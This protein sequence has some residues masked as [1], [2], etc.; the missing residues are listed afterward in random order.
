M[1]SRSLFYAAILIY[2]NSLAEYSSVIYS[3]LGNHCPYY[4]VLM[5]KAGV[6]WS[7]CWFSSINLIIFSVITKKSSSKKTE[8]NNICLWWCFFCVISVSTSIIFDVLFASIIP[9][10]G[11]FYQL[12]PTR[13][14]EWLVACFC[15]AISLNAL[16]RNCGIFRRIFDIIPAKRH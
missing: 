6:C 16:L 3:W 1:I 11:G 5:G 13:P 10:C 8:S 2:L 14:W 15:I 12:W 7:V 9:M 4:I